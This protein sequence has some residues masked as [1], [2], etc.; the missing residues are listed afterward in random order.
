MPQG[1][2]GFSVSLPSYSFRRDSSISFQLN[3]TGARYFYVGPSI[4]VY[5]RQNQ[6][7]NRA[8]RDVSTQYNTIVGVHL[9]LDHESNYKERLI[10]HAK[11]FYPDS[12]IPDNSDQDT[13]AWVAFPMLGATL[14]QGLEDLMAPVS[15]NLQVASGLRAFSIEEMTRTI[16]GEAP[17]Q[18]QAAAAQSLTK[19]SK[20]INIDNL[21]VGS[22]LKGYL[23]PNSLAEILAADFGH[24]S[25]I[26]DLDKI[27][28]KEIRLLLRRFN[29]KRIMRLVLGLAENDKDRFAG[30]TYML[31]RDAA[32]QYA[33]ARKN[34]PDVVMDLSRQFRSIE[35]VHD[36]ITHEYRKLKNPNLEISYEKGLVEGLSN[37]SLP[38]GASLIWP[39]SSHE[40]LEWSSDGAMNNCIFSYG[41]EA[42]ENQCLLLA[43]IDASGKMV[44]NVMIKNGEVVQ[45]Y[46]K[47]NQYC[48]DE[49]Q[50][51][52]LFDGLI[53]ERII[54]EESDYTRWLGNY[55][56]RW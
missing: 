50:L 11:T 52:A 47:A 32:H 42:A 54:N 5:R 14:K 35:E 3:P 37:V 48:T 53:S 23:P 46:G 7:Q 25:R 9:G 6:A 12:V 21:T 55:R 28:A 13:L 1:S 31:L 34:H 4:G 56:P 10:K 39:S 2:K 36:T 40:L 29:S 17:R 38:D 20:V 30:H 44:V 26:Q 19:D 43:I 8:L 24:R 51:K 45:C 18:L 41:R 27:S 16:F 33:D 22:L 15:V 49:P